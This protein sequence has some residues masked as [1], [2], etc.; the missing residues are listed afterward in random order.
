MES[1][2]PRPVKKKYAKPQLLTY[3]DIREITQNVGNMGAGGDGGMGMNNK[4][5]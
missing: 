4:T 1:Q 3:G 5:R 2:N